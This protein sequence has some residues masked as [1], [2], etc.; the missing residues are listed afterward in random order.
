MRR[1]EKRERLSPHRERSRVRR[2]E[3]PVVAAFHQYREREF[4]L[5]YSLRLRANTNATV[6][7]RVE[8]LESSQ[9]G[10]ESEW[11]PSEIKMFEDNRH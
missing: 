8:S 7:E 4:G 5:H 3:V 10:M 9:S 6:R 2:Q 1:A 11:V